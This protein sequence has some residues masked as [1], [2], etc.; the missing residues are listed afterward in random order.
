M[1]DFTRADPHLL[2][3]LTLVQVIYALTIVGFASS[4][5]LSFRKSRKAKVVSEAQTSDALA[6]SL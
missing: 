5:W 6:G 4:L 3:G 1:V 2:W